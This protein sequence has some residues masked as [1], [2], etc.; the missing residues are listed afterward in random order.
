MTFFSVASRHIVA[1]RKRTLLRAIMHSS[2]IIV[3]DPFR[4]L[5]QSVLY[6]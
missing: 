3:P 4:G 1:I 5:V 6:V 2:L